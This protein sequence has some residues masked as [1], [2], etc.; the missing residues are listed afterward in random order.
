VIETAIDYKTLYE[1]LVAQNATLQQELANLKRIIFGSKNERFVPS[2]SAPSQLTLDIQADAVAACSV[3]KM[4]KIEYVR[5]STQVTREHPGLT[6]LPEHLERR[7]I[8]IEPTQVIEAC[9][10]IGEEITEELEYEPGKF[11][12]NRYVRPKY[13]KQIVKVSPLRPWFMA[14][15][16]KPLLALVCWHKL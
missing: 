7:E 9:K 10:K 1:Q 16:I 13:V 6:K 5:N 2:E 12:V 8:I 4:Q 3:T 11:F 14:L 15:C